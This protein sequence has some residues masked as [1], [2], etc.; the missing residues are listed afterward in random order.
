LK[1][2]LFIY[3][4]QGILSIFW[5]AITRNRDFDLDFLKLGTVLVH[6]NSAIDP[7]IYACRMRS[8]R[9]ALH[10]ICPMISCLIGPSI[11]QYSTTRRTIPTTQ[12]S[13]PT[14]ITPPSAAEC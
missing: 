10:D 5:L 2:Y 1:F 8:I 6:L 14:R 12:S 7:I 11:P 3:F 4:K 9:V 13:S